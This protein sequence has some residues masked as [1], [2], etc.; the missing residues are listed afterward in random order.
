MLRFI[1]LTFAFVLLELY[2]V[3]PPALAGLGSTKPP[4]KKK[5]KRSTHSEEA[6]Q[7]HYD[8]GRS[9]AGGGSSSSYSSL[10]FD[11]ERY[12]DPRDPSGY[13]QILGLNP[14]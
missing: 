6:Q 11:G 2:P 10:D 3:H 5:K 14:G 1:S 9:A 4:P 13:Y 12:Y 8:T 7:Q